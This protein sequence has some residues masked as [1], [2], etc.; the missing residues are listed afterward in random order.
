MSKILFFGEPLIRISPVQGN[1]FGNHCASN[2][3]FGGSE[4][5][6]A[7]NLQGFGQATRL[8]LALPN[9]SIG[10]S[11]I[12][13]LNSASID[14]RPIQRV[15]NRIGLYFLGDAFG[16]RQ[17]EVIY[18]RSDSSLHDFKI[19]ATDFDQLFDD[20]A[21]LH[22]SGITLAL[23]DT[24]RQNTL[25]LIQEAKNRHVLISFDLNFRSRLISPRKAKS[26]FSEFAHYADYCFG[27]EPLMSDHQDTE[28]F[29]RETATL[30][31]I[32]NRMQTLIKT[33]HFRAIFHTSRRQDEW[34]RNVFR[35]YLSTAGGEMFTSPELKTAVLQRVGSGDA[36]VAGAL[37]QLMQ[38][39]DFQTIVDFAAASATLK[40]TLEGDNMFEPTHRVTQVLHQ[41]RDI[42]R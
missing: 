1:Y 28:F 30:K 12:Q 26:L 42:M 3:F 31:D 39:Q 27:I 32:E 29:D 19:E 21:L 4:V 5:N 17:G 34:S 38:D 14:T 18:D 33:F 6:I 40:C 36:F 24:V 41:T 16:C 20:V 7:R 2:L 25:Q 35:A 8:A 37:Y 9:N 23:G 11:F 13:F 15:G 10:D 22:F